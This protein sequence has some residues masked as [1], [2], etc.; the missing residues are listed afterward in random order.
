MGGGHWGRLFC[1][2]DGIDEDFVPFWANTI[3]LRVWINQNSS[4]ICSNIRKLLKSRYTTC[5]IFT[6]ATWVGRINFLDFDIRI[7]H[8]TK[9]PFPYERFMDIIKFV[10]QNS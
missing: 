2:S 8:I 3:T 6:D 5:M 7:F 1:V 10:F 9:K 4:Q